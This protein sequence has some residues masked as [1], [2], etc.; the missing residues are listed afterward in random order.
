MAGV[1][2][3]MDEYVSAAD[4]TCPGGPP[5]ELFE[6]MCPDCGANMR[7]RQSKFGLF[8]GCEAYP[9][10][11]GSHGAYPDGR[12][13]GIPGNKVT[14]DARILAHRTFDKLWD[15]SATGYSKMTRAA[16]YRWMQRVMGVTKELAHIGMFNIPMC[17]KLIILVNQSRPPRLTVMQR[18]AK[19]DW[20]L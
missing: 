5:G 16:A 1:R 20:L 17:T 6:M 12:P 15:D 10:C 2:Y 14:R 11:K 8:Y 9:A 4:R 18:L 19:D 3:C 7:L 13:R